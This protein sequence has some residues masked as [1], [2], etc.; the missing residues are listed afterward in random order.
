[1]SESDCNH[2][3]ARK[4]RNSVLYG[5]ESE[6]SDFISTLD[7]SQRKA[8]IST[9]GDNDDLS[10]LGFLSIKNQHAIIKKL[11]ENVEVD[12]TCL[13]SITE[14]MEDCVVCGDEKLLNYLL[15]L[16]NKISKS[17]LKE[18]FESQLMIKAC[19]KSKKPENQGTIIQLLYDN[20]FRIR[21]IKKQAEK[22]K[23]NTEFHYKVFQQIK[24]QCSSHYLICR[25]D[26]QHAK[27]QDM[28]D[29]TKV[30]GV[31]SHETNQEI[32][33]IYD[34]STIFGIALPLFETI[35]NAKRSNNLYSVEYGLLSDE[36]E[37]FLVE[38]IHLSD[39][40]REHLEIA[41]VGTQDLDVFADREFIPLIKLACDMELKNFATNKVFKGMVDNLVTR[42]KK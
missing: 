3:H 6:T 7:P 28:D 38:L 34:D 23:I 39:S 11:L 29:H 14:A 41:K 12:E 19:I 16:F 9:I 5:S 37:E 40:D 30:R 18:D 4:I 31:Y 10:L 26:E 15:Q 13:N 20:G 21:E 17:G 2:D 1:M 32:P 27:K 33:S 42:Y 35:R 22:S 25:A 36:L 8:V 24:A